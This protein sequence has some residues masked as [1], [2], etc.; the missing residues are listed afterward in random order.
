MAHILQEMIREHALEKYSVCSEV[1]VMNVI[2]KQFYLPDI[3]SVSQAMF[4]AR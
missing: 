3:V 1:W 2:Y 4:T